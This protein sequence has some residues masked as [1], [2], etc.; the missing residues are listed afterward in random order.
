MAQ[1]F[2][3]A[4]FRKSFDA[5]APMTRAQRL[6]SVNCRNVQR[7]ELKRAFAG[8]GLL[9]DQAFV[10]AGVAGCFFDLSV[11]RVF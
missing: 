10:L 1:H 6:R 9:E 3:L 5:F 11:H 2:N 4:D 8:R 7:R